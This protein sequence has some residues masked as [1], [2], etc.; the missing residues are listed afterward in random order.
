M[1]EDLAVGPHGYSAEKQVLLARLKRVEGQ[2]RGLQ[3]M[4]DEDT[5]CIDVLTQIS[6]ASRSGVVTHAAC[7][8]TT[9]LSPPR[10]SG[11]SD[12]RRAATRSAQRPRPRA[13][14]DGRG[15]MNAP[16]GKGGAFICS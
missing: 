15:C 16:P 11:P 2:V 12:H 4:V 10:S 3:R 5:Y 14:R 7:G 9:G 6:A 8:L 1:D 13:A